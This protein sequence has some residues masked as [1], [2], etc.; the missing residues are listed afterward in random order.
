MSHSTLS[1]APTSSSVAHSSTSSIPSTSISKSSS[2]SVSSQ[3]PSSSSSKA[4]RSAVACTSTKVVSS[5]VVVTKT[6]MNTQSFTVTLHPSIVTVTQTITKP[7]S[8]A[9]VTQS[10]TKT[11][12]S[13]STAAAQHTCAAAS[14][15]TDITTSCKSFAG[16]PYCAIHEGNGITGV[17]VSCVPLNNV[18]TSNSQCC[19]GFSCSEHDANDFGFCRPFSAN[20]TGLIP[21]SRSASKRAVDVAT[22]ATVSSSSKILTITVTPTPSVTKS[23]TTSVTASSTQPPVPKNTCTIE[24]VTDGQNTWLYTQYYFGAGYTLSP[25]NEG[26]NA[27][28]FAPVTTKFVSSLTDCQAIAACAQN[29]VYQPDNYWNFDLHYSGNAWVCVQYINGNDDV[30][31]WNVSDSTVTKAYGFSVHGV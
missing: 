27:N 21:P 16:A 30:T 6:L 10:A 4:K 3:N 13:T 14:D 18:C 24:E 19:T 8:V 5:T 22:S 7:P 17:C 2:S 26:N 28:G 29:S 25:A 20:A 23:A 9:T 31:A 1:A 12:S 15:L 11:A